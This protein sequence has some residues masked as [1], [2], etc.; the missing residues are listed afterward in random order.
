MRDVAVCSAIEALSSAAFSCEQAAHS[1]RTRTRPAQG[2]ARE[3]ALPTISDDRTSTSKR[4]RDRMFP[5]LDPLDRTTPLHRSISLSR[6]K[7]FQSQRFP[8]SCQESTSER[9]SPSFSPSLVPAASDPGIF[10]GERSASMTGVLQANVLIEH[11]FSRI[12]PIFPRS[13]ARCSSRAPSPHPAT[14]AWPG[15]P[16]LQ[17]C[18]A[19]L[20]RHSQNLLPKSPQSMRKKR[21]SEPSENAPLGFGSGALSRRCAQECPEGNSGKHTKEK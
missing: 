15:T 7:A 9:H 20:F 4:C 19:L 17:H 3:G 14:I 18:A 13:L 10:P 11:Q 2:S 6:L 8:N 12:F 5:A 1:H 16:I 21:F